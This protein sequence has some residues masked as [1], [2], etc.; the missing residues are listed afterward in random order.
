MDDNRKKALAAALGQIEKQFGKGSVMRLGDAGAARDIDAVST[1]SIGLDAA[2][3]IGGLPKGRVVEIYGPESSGKT[4]LTLQVVAEAQKVGGTAAFVD[5]EHALDPAYAEKLGVNVDELLVS[6]PDTGEQAL[7]ITDML[8][9]SGAVDVIVVDSVAALTPKAE[10]EGEMGDSHMGLQARLM[11]QALRKLTGNIKRSNAMVIFIN[12]IRMKIGV[13]FGSPETTTGGN[14]LKFYSSVRLDIRRIG[15][16]K[17]GDEVIGNQTRVK[18]VK[19]K[20]SPPFKNA[21][22][23]ILYGEGISR[24]GEI[25][26]HGVNQG[27]IEKSGSWYSYGKDRIGQGKENV[28][29]YLKE[30]PD[31]AATIEQ[32]IRATLLPDTV[33]QPAA[34]ADGA[35]EAVAS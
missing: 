31:I 33:K 23:E 4:T 19:N 30:N 28:R 35:D 6:Q 7:E 5:A 34:A 15:A 10:I 26:E 20:V 25:I 24:E 11:S 9:R 14:A 13:M 1:G 3:G 8:V 22:F 27:I 12:Q 2:L 16:I 17:K 21:E 32:Q 29:N 18:V